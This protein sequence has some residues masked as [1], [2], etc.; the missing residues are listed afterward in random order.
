M[1]I[2]IYKKSILIIIINIDHSNTFYNCNLISTNKYDNLQKNNS[3][4]MYKSLAPITIW[5][6]KEG[7]LY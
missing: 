2:E 7:R 5:N 4:K 3:Y 1:G 6:N